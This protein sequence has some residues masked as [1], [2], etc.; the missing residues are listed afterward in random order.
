MVTNYRVPPPFEEGK[1]Y[2]SWKNEVSVWTRVTD[3]EKK[4]QALAVA[5]ALSGRARET[6]ME[7]AVD[8]L[9][10][11]TGMDTLLAKLDNLFLK[12]EKDRTYDAYSDFDR[13]LRDGNV[14]MADYIIDFEQRYSRMRKYK[15]ELPDAVLAF[16]LLDT[17]CLDVTDRQLALTACADLTFASMKSALKRIFGG[18]T[19]V[20]SDGI[21]R[22]S[23]FVTEQRRQK[24]RSWQQMTRP[25]TPQPGTNPLDKFGR[26]S[27]CAVC[28]STFHWAK[29][30][31]NKCDSVKFTED[32]TDVEECNI[33]L[34]T[35]ESPTDAEI[36]MTECFGSAII[37]TACTRTVCGQEW[38]DNYTTV[39]GKKNVKS[40]RKTEIQSHRPFKFGDGK[41]VYSVKKVKIPAK[42]GNTRCNIETEVVPVNIPLLL[43]KTSLKRAGTVLDMEHDSAVMFNQPVKLDFTSSGH[44]CVNIVDSENKCPNDDQILTTTEEEVLTCTDKMNTS[45]KMKVLEKLHKQ[46]GHASADKL[47]R[48]LSSSGN[49]DTECNSLLQKVISECE[50]CQKY[51]KTK[52]KPAVGLPLASTYNE[53]VAVDLHELEPGLWYLH[54]IDQFTRF[55]A[56]SVLTTKRSSEIVKHFIHDW[57][58][59]HGPPRKLFSDNGGEFNNEEV[60]D[61]AENFNIEVRTTPGYSP[62]SNGLL[63][64]HNQTLTEIILKVKTSTGCDWTTAMDWALMAKNCMQSVH[65]YSPHQLVF[66]QNPNLPSV[67]ID[68]APALEG[69]TKSEWVAKH[70][71]ALHTARKAFT[72]AEC[73]ERI[74]RA[75]KK[76]LR[77]NDEKYELGDK[78]FYK[79]VDC[80]EWKGPGVVIGQDGAV[81]FVRHGGTCVRVHQLRLR[82][83]TQEH[84]EPHISCE[85]ED[86]EE[87]RSS[88]TYED[89]EETNVESA[90][91]DPLS[92]S[93]NAATERQDDV[94]TNVK[95]GQIVT[96]RHAPNGGSQTAKVLGR[97]GKAT[98]KYKS[99][100]NLELLKPAEVAG[101]IAAVDLSQLEDL[102]V[103]V[104]ASSSDT[105]EDVFVTKDVTFDEAKTS[106]IKSWIQN[107]VFEEVEDKGQKCISTRWVCTLKETENGLVPK[108]RLVARGFE[109]L[110]VSELQKDS[111]TCAS[112]SL[113]LLVAVSCQKQWQLHSMDIKSAFLQGLELSRDIF[114]KPPYEANSTGKLWKL[115]KCVY[116]LADASL[117]WYNR[118]KSIM[119]EAGGIISKVD[120]AVFYWLDENKT[121]TGVLA[122]HVDDF[123]W[124]GTQ[125]F[126]MTVIPYLKSKFNVG[127]EAQDS[128]SYVG[129]DFVTLEK[130]VQIHQETYIQQLQPIPLAPARAVEPGSP[131]TEAERDQLRSKIGQLLW[132][133]RQTR[134]DVMFDASK[135]ASDLKQ[136]TVQTIN[137]ANRVVCKLKAKSVELNFQHLGEDS[138]LK[139]VTFT[140]ASFANLADGG[141]QGGHLIVL[142]GDNGQFSPISWQSKRIKR[143]V[144]STLA[145]ETLAMSEG[146]DNAIFLSILFSELNAGCTDHTVPIICVTDS[147]SLVDALK[148]TKFVTEKRL[149]LEISSIKELIQTQRVHQVLWSDT[150]EQLADCLTKKGA[151]SAMLLKALSDGR[152]TVN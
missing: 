32:K 123:I 128:F 83:V 85:K 17:A 98:G 70:I 118:V 51:C 131:L 35:K 50:V 72:E 90:D 79:R 55:S 63:E 1:P 107:E 9:N 109:E 73:S 104:Q 110:Q 28:Q 78:V 61:M 143:I 31:P 124:G 58:S 16:K 19:S 126:S 137:E 44:Y 24:G 59:I 122:C 146:I 96:F 56:G 4:K 127:R 105:C 103:Q 108:A 11:D 64:R 94:N 147:F 106:E 125:M 132:V 52:P 95:T 8:D 6:A 53:T 7:I 75:L 18:K 102:Q 38:L 37:D 62:W 138:N 26:R 5:L 69:T 133:A 27:K 2:E 93:E 41:V 54:I 117:Y 42:I 15:M 116:G 129:V 113:R 22:E 120:P 142:M 99:W 14:S 67:L 151:S 60:R 33:T 152:W 88:D 77:H 71:S 92:A 21:S 84:E 135:L 29:D 111:P 81:V 144:R 30:C 97:A 20:S 12:E 101:N 134:P 25:K 76:Q 145:G 57:I 49:K 80:P 121:V 82:K 68:R 34:Y 140:D 89:I 87:Q 86:G 148:S 66:G 43:S 23:V 119:I 141:T 112:E 65:G 74:R 40:M 114:I 3:L 136:A 47:Q 48:L 115:R 36:F 10:K 149:R 45:E 91:N 39:S 100:Y 13:I 130:K 46:F 150:K 139:I